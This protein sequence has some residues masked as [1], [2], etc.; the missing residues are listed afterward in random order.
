MTQIQNT[1]RANAEDARA[2]RAGEQ[3]S[4]D[5]NALTAEQNKE[6]R[7]HNKAVEKEQKRSNQAT[8]LW[9]GEQLDFQKKS[10]VANAIGSGL[11]GLGTAAVL[12]F[13][14]ISWYVPD[15]KVADTIL[16]LPSADPLGTLYPKI[17]NAGVLPANATLNGQSDLTPGAPSILTMVTTPTLGTSTAYSNVNKAADH[18]WML[19]NE[20]NGRNSSYEPAD[21]MM[22][23]LSIANHVALI[24][25]LE[26]IYTWT[27]AFSAEDTTLPR[28][29]LE[30]LQCN[31]DD[32]VDH[33]YDLAALIEYYKA[34]LKPYRLMRQIKLIDRWAYAYGS[35]LCDADQ[36]GRTQWYQYMPAGFYKL[37]VT[38]TDGT[39]LEWKKL[40]RSGASGHYGRPNGADL[41]TF[42]DLRAY[43]REMQQGYYAAQDVKIMNSD[44]TSF[45]GEEASAYV[46]PDTTMPL[47]GKPMISTDPWA[48]YQF[49]NAYLG[50]QCSLSSTDPVIE[51]RTETT[52][53]G[54]SFSYVFSSDGSGSGSGFN[55]SWLLEAPANATSA[56]MLIE[57]S[58]LTVPDIGDAGTA[59]RFITERPNLLYMT[60]VSSRVGA[61]GQNGDAFRYTTDR[62]VI[63]HYIIASNSEVSIVDG[64]NLSDVNTNFGA[65]VSPVPELLINYLAARIAFK[66]CPNTHFVVNNALSDATTRIIKNV[67]TNDWETYVE[68]SNDRLAKAN[69]RIALHMF[70]VADF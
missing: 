35:M 16:S 34:W 44:I 1:R 50:T 11:G 48:L 19:I 46:F 29:V 43:V 18:L 25:F 65:G 33:R 41:L 39:K 61:A 37:N 52:E 22:Y 69:E 55:G 63:A 23:Q 32:M 6:Q 53:T 17:G 24:S 5:R 60:K 49:K 59:G 47:A 70:G 13:N 67:V 36:N 21:L 9:R 66:Y 14:D 7:R 38:N 31:F 3:I 30:A 62:P 10:M 40:A 54:A 12:A 4:K 42:D 28:G 15:S 20:R 56:D 57:V 58:R 2:N 8:E 26:K 27:T 51:Q 45:V 68:V 64:E